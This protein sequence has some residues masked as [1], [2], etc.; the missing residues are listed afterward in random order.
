M[1]V[2][3]FRCTQMI[4]GSLL[5]RR[6]ALDARGWFERGACIFDRRAL[7]VRRLHK[8]ACIVAVAWI[9]TGGSRFQVFVQVFVPL[10]QGSRDIFRF[11]LPHQPFAGNERGPALS[12]LELQHKPPFGGYLVLCTMP[13]HMAQDI[14]VTAK[15]IH[16]LWGQRKLASTVAKSLILDS[17]CQGGR[18]LFETIDCT[19]TEETNG[20]RATCSQRCARGWKQA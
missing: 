19:S 17:R 15:M 16:D 12:Y 8:P 1:L 6:L 7:C 4:P 10:L 18:K 5:R 14:T 2:I 11:L 13:S 20:T 3:H 9:C